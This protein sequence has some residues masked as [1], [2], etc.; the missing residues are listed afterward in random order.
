MGHVLADLE[1]HH[2]IGLGKGLW[3][4]EVEPLEEPVTKDRSRD[5][6]GGVFLIV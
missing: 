4:G 3:L 5:P 2:P 1:R 6:Q